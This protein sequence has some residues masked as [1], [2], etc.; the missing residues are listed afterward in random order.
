VS[1]PDAP[2]TRRSA[3]LLGATGL[4]GGFCLERL[5]ADPTYTEVHV[6]GRR[7]LELRHPRLIEHLIDFDRLAEL[8]A[9]FAVNDVFCCL[10]TTIRKAGSQEAFRRVDVEY[11]VTAA[12]LAAEAGAEQFLVISAV[13]AE[14]ESR[15]FYNRAKGEMETH[16]RQV[17]LQA[18][19]IIRPALQLGPRAERRFGERLAELFFRPLAPL[20]V[21]R[22][23][24]YRPVEAEMVA[25]AMVNL[26]RENGTGGV[27]ESEELPRIAERFKLLEPGPR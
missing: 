19:W 10:G 17:P 3:L 15:V 7:S 16:V 25:N 8:G 13:G 12:R 2:V 22:L 18:L 6:V 21:G 27:V 14:P 1:G 9:L 23:R 5:L 26:A 11:P 4:V 20:M 24:R